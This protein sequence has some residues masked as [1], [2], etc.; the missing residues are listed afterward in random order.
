MSKLI[1]MQG[2]PGSGKTTRAK[3]IMERDGNCV[4]VGRDQLRTMLH[5]DKWNGRNEGI[6]KDV[7]NVVVDYLLKQGKV[8][9]V[10]DT[11]IQP[12]RIMAWKNFAKERGVTIQWERVDTPIEECI[13]R[14]AAREKPVT[15]NVI[16]AMAMQAGLYPKP[17]KGFV[18]CD[19][20]GTL[21]DIKHRLHF[22]QKPEGEKK[23]WKGFFSG[24]SED[25]VNE[26]VREM[27]EDAQKHGGYEIA[28]V[29]GRP[30][31]HRE[32]TE[33]WLQRHVLPYSVLLMR[34]AGDKRPDTETKKDIL[35]TYFLNNGYKVAYAIDDRPSVIRMWGENGISVVDVGD[36]VEF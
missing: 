1:L 34:R 21:C 26:K 4:R 12:S 24:I 8:V 16:V 31:D 11:N 17:E 33:R 22:V 36:G 25:S 30:D 13:K 20:D 2:L 35:D 14:D 5:F 10:D 7:A 15:K 19:L 29:S 18:I 3:E 28:F 6:T 9:I 27:L 32:V 23:D